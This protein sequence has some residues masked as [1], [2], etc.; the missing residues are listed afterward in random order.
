MYNQISTQSRDLYTLSVFQATYENADAATGFEDLTFT[1]NN[2]S[3]QGTS[4]AVKYD[5][6]I[7][8]SLFGTIEDKG[9]TM[10]LVQDP[11]GW[12]IAWSS[13]DIFDGLAA[14]A[15]IR[16]IA[17]PNT[18]A[19]IYD[20]NG[21]PVVEQ[22]ATVVAIYTRR[23][24]IANESACIDLLATLLRRQR[25]DLVQLFSRFLPES[26]FYLGEL[27]PDVAAANSQQLF[28]LCAVGEGQKYER[29]TR[30]YYRGNAVSH[31][32]GY[33]G[34]I[35][36]D[37]VSTWESRGYQAG[38][39]IG[40]TGIEGAFEEQLSGKAQRILRII[41]PGGT[42]IRSLGSTQGTP[43]APVMLTIDR[44]LQVV[45]AQALA[46]AYNF[47]EGNWGARSVSTGAAAVV[48]DVNTG[49][50]LAMSSYPLFEPDIFNPDTYCCQPLTAGD[51]IAEIFADSRRPLVNRVFLDQ[52]SP[53]S[54]YKIV[55]TAAA[56]GEN[57][58]DPNEIF[59]CDLEWADGPKFGD[60]A[61]FIRGDWRKWE[62]EEYRFPTGDVTMSQ[63]LTSSCDPFFYQVSAQLFSQ[64][65]PAILV[66]YARRMGLGRMTG[67]NYYGPEAAG[68]IPI[69]ANVTEAI[70]SGIGQGD[71]KVTPI[72]MVR[73]AAAIANG[74]KVFQPYL[75]QQIGGMDGTP[76][77]FQAA[78]VVAVEMGLS[79]DVLAIVR[80]G[81]CEVTTNEKLGT[82]VWPFEG[83][84]YHACGKTGTAQTSRY[85]NAWFVSY[86]PAENPQIAIAVVVEQ[87]LEGSQVAAPI[88][89]RIMDAYMG[90][91]VWGYPPFWRDP[92]TPL[93]VPEGGTYGG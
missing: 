86:V 34:Q 84:S 16:S 90:D 12:R 56:A 64:R 7:S 8:S 23:Q 78:P 65:G 67:I 25:Q 29:Q 45:V 31:V 22:G 57:I 21:Q 15:Q 92:Y 36:V 20:R 27:D 58:R 44:D 73:I 28:E 66:D 51:R 91:P 63:A 87:S 35:P 54:T 79:E 76:V 40:R 46:D 50:I 26:A 30:R 85:P 61:G 41:E 62:P 88:T 19:N 5:V 2:V 17:Q 13:M 43:P 75:V 83:T 9:R 1:I 71:V 89:R 72:Q 14:G 33:V 38:D 53:G 49:A 3:L 24:N 4:A 47:A 60:T 81:M 37:Q 48:M 68:Q 11:A 55:T 74:G 82:A 10:R 52:F 32:T 59:Y 42:P 39:L 6:A 70:N 93:N 77:T 18:R 80:E 69:P